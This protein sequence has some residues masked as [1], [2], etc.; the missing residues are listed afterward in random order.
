LG[1]TKISLPPSIQD[2]KPSKKWY[3][4]S[5]KEPGT[6]NE[7]SDEQST[8]AQIQVLIQMTGTNLSNTIS[9]RKKREKTSNV[10]DYYNIGSVLGEGGFA[11]VCEGTDK[12]TNQKV[13]V[14]NDSNK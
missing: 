2:G 10:E 9:Q 8:T 12:E 13:A 11:I 6:G 3:L 5:E 7:N 1:S 14:K 4:L